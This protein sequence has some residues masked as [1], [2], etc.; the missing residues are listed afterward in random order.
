MDISAV[1]SQYGATYTPPV[2]PNP[3]Q[4]TAAKYGATYTPPAV[5]STLSKVGSFL[6][7][8]NLPTYIPDSIDQAKNAFMNP[9][10][11]LQKAGS[12]A[13]GAVDA[14]FEPFS[15]LNK[16]N[17]DATMAADA[18]ATPAQKVAG[19]ASDL[20]TIANIM[21]AP[22]SAAFAAAKEVPGLKLAADVLQTPFAVTGKVGDF[23]AEK[24]VDVLPI[25]QASKDVL[26]P[27][28][29]QLGALA[30]Q[31]LL[32]GKVM[33]LVGKGYE[34]F[35]AEKVSDL[36]KETTDQTE[37]FKQQVTSHPAVIG[38]KYGATYTPP[39]G[40]PEGTPEKP[41]VEEVGKKTSMSVDNLVSHEGAPDTKT[42][43]QYKSD[44]QAGR[45]LEPLKIVD[46]GNGKYGVEDGKHRL[47]AY[48]EL[49]F[50]EVPIE[51]TTQEIK[52]RS[53]KIQDTKLNPEQEVKVSKLSSDI[54]DTLKR[55]YEGLPEYNTMNMEEQAKKA[56]DLAKSDPQL[57]HDVA[58]GD[59]AAP[60]GIREGSIFTAARKM[61]EAMPDPI[62]RG[63]ALLDLAHSKLASRASELGQQVKAFD[64]MT[65]S[66]DPVKSIKE[67]EK[68]REGSKN[69]DKEA[70]KD[71]NSIKKEIK[72]ASPKKGDWSS[73][74]E[75]IKC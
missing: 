30:G 66:E 36:V 46:E 19:V 60:D 57:F 69:I 24:F 8:S 51:D 75:S 40:A 45:A 31:V 7:I 72:K 6:G 42:V 65:R 59:K 50:T 21:F 64:D 9:L 18:K 4:S 55:D 73:F 5:P 34:K 38:E 67:I 63:Q 41:P 37:Q 25:D 12:A 28:F 68:A 10:Q 22:V 48:K 33:D 71:E 44:I 61:A 27:A 58:M 53:Q 39:E 56:V 20:S 23:A 17:Y 47:Q 14:A 54:A 16:D 11:T 35:T 2:A 15:A 26:K 29:G 49:G 74:I 70:K 52:D 13:Y 43:E 1:Q 32:G 3:Y 62:E